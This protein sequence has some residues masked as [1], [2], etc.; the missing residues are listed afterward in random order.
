MASFFINLLFIFTDDDSNNRR[1]YTQNLNDCNH[2]TLSRAI[3]RCHPV[4]TDHVEFE[5]LIP[6]LNEHEIFTRSEMEYFNNRYYSN[7]EKVNK[8]I[9]WLP[10]KDE[11]GIH[12][13]VRALNEA[14]KH[15]GHSTIL[16]HLYE[17]ACTNTTV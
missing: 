15:S 14:H 11:N 10:K 17:I 2:L 8:L 16:K 12:N 1:I 4:I 9:E 3:E 7:A 13:F 5:T 6:F